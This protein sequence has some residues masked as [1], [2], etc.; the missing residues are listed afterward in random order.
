MLYN[1]KKVYPCF[2]YATLADE[3]T[4][5]GVSWKYYAPQAGQNGYQ[6]NALNSY[7]Q[8]RGPTYDVP[9]QHFATDAANNQLP[10]FSWLV[11]PSSSSE[12]P[13]AGSGTPL[14]M[15]AGENWTVQQINA[16]EN[17]PSWKST[18]IILTWDDYGGFY[19]HVA[20]TNVDALGYG[21]RVPLLVISPYAHADDNH[22][23]HISHDSFE[24][25]SVLKL[26]EETYNLP[27]LNRRDVTAGDLMKTL[28][29]SL[30]WNKPLLLSQRQCP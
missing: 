24:F 1:G 22:N 8:D 6:W 28:D 19:D 29:F 23:H 5:A 26:A 7:S 20:P 14:S 17:S 3:M 16:V 25:S 18:V 12:H 21:F 27:S 11:P 9:W 15:C 4:A 30:V 10:A 2:T 13:V